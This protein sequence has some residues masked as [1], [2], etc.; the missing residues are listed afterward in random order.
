[1]VAILASML[2]TGSTLTGLYIKNI[3]EQRQKAEEAKRVAEDARQEAD[4]ARGTTRRSWTVLL[5]PAETS[6]TGNWLSFGAAIPH[7]RRELTRLRNQP[8]EALRGARRGTHRTDCCWRLQSPFL[9][10]GTC[11]FATMPDAWP[12][13]APA[14]S[15]SGP[16][17]RRGF[18]L[19][20]CVRNVNGITTTRFSRS[21]RGN[22]AWKTAVTA[23]SPTAAMEPSGVNVS[24]RVTAPSRSR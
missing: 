10:L 22:I 20:Y 13:V 16:P 9:Q 12:L 21:A 24:A 17:R 1:M 19:P 15:P 8:C 11:H 5:R 18:A 6:L 7:Q 2:V 14:A 23:H 4:K 3:D